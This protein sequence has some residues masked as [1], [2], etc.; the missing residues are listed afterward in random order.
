MEVHGGSGVVTHRSHATSIRSK[1][2]QAYVACQKWRY[3]V[4]IAALAGIILV[5]SLWRESVLP[6]PDSQ[7]AISSAPI[8]GKQHMTVADAVTGAQEAAERARARGKGALTSSPT[9]GGG[10]GGVRGYKGKPKDAMDVQPTSFDH[11]PPR[12][13]VKAILDSINFEGF[14]GTPAVETLNPDGVPMIDPRCGPV[15][16]HTK[17]VCT[18]KNEGADITHAK[19]RWCRANANWLMR[20]AQEKLRERQVWFWTIDSCRLQWFTVEEAKDCIAHFGNVVMV[21]DSLTRYQYINLAYFLSNGWW[22]HPTGHLP[23]APDLSNEHE[24]RSRGSWNQAYF[25]V[26]NKAIRTEHCDCY[27]PNNKWKSESTENRYFSDPESG[28]R[29]TYFQNW[30]RVTMQGHSAQGMMDE[31][32]SRCV[33]GTCGPPYDWTATLP[34]FPATILTNLN[35]QPKAVIANCGYWE[36]PKDMVHEFITRARYV[37][38]DTRLIWKST[39]VAGPSTAASRGLLAEDKIN[40]ETASKSGWELFRS[41]TMTGGLTM[42]GATWDASEAN[43]FGRHFRGFVYQS[44]NTVLLSHLCPRR[45]EVRFVFHMSS[46]P[47]E[48]TRRDRIQQRQRER[49][50]KDRFRNSMAP[51]KPARHKQ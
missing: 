3:V 30:G 21:G 37:L 50:E 17:P 12:Q 36:C 19:G 41:R 25:P 27:R 22:P 43:I 13:R 34:H 14:R 4:V 23:D 7:P 16:D 49:V 20:P 2:F 39:T 1:C 6:L 40:R 5:S 29:L 47:D 38:P 32:G 35:P 24:W 31:H 9:Q 48:Q 8:T 45:D 18:F 33:P 46:Q 51:A 42:P 28:A 11:L 10:G 26:T 44:M 15:P